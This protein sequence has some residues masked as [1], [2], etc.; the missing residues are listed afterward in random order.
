M[1]NKVSIQI[2]AVIYHNQKKNLLKTIEHIHNA[3]RTVTDTVGRVE[4]VYGDASKTP[5]FSEEEVM[6]IT[7]RFSDRL[8]FRYVF[9]NENTGFGKGQNLLGDGCTADYILIMNPDIIVTPT[10]FTEMLRPFSDTTVGMTE[11]RQTP[12]E[13]HKA[14]DFNTL[15]TGWASLACAMVPTTLWNQLDGI[16]SDSFFMY[17][18][19]VDF[20]WRLRL[21]GYKI[22]YCPK[23][24]VYHAKRL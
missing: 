9:F 15:E 6:E 22:I 1:N 4:F 21:L 17:C 3:L 13:H 8:Q 19:D 24:P 2:Q 18:E 7:R 5:T 10:F 23:A 20:S 16:D 14:Y 11:A 12:V